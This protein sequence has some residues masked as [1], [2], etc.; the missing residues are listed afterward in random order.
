MSASTIADHMARKQDQSPQYDFLWRVELPSLDL[1]GIDPTS[2]NAAS[3]NP[4][5][6]FMDQV[7]ANPQGLYGNVD[8]GSQRAVTD[9]DDLNHRVYNIETPF[10]TFD[11]HAANGGSYKFHTAHHKEIGEMSITMDEFED[12]KTLKYI[13]DWTG[14]ILRPDGTHNPPAM[15]KKTIRV[16]RLS[17]TKLDLHVSTY[18]GCFL[19]G[20][21]PLNLSQE[22]DGVM[23][24]ALSIMPDKVYH[25]V[26]PESR[27]RAMIWE[28]EQEIM[29]QGID[30]QWFKL[31]GLDKA[32]QSRILDRVIDFL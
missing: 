20:V 4:S 17:A 28:A 1:S 12:G 19:Q 21:S 10:Y 11:A 24:Y 30:H 16:Y 27:T 22:G 23:Q 8:T 9:M 18:E 7:Q 25:E 3:R 5:G 26:V 31:G 32:A 6:G 15:Y 29:A 2:N 13:N 14:L